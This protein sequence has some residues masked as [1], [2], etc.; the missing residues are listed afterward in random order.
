M[1]EFKPV[2]CVWEFTLACDLRCGHCGSRAGTARPDEMDTAECLG[3]VGSLARLGGRLIT[4]SGG[5]PTLRPDWE[6]VAKAIR[7]RGMIANIVTNG[8]SMTAELARRMKDAGLANAAVSIDGPEAVHEKIRGRGTFAKTVRALSFLADAGVST[9]IMT[10]ANKLNLAHLEETCGMAEK[11]GAAS[12]RVQLGKSMGNLKDRDDWVL[13]PEDLLDL[14]PRLYRLESKGGIRVHIGD[15]IGFYGPYDSRLRA[16][17]WDGKP[18]RWG[19]CQAGLQAIGI[20]S[21]GNIKG[22][23]SMQAFSDRDR[24]PFVE[25]NVRE[26]ALS[27]IWN[28]PAAFSYNRLFRAADLTGFCKT[29]RYAKLCR[30]GAKCVAAAMGPS[31]FEDPYCYYRVSELV[32]QRPLR[33]VAR[34]MAAAASAFSLV[35]GG[36]DVAVTSGDAGAVVE[37]SG[38]P[39]E[40]GGV[41]GDAAVGQDAGPAPDGGGTNCKDVCCECEYGVIPPDVYEECCAIQPEYGVEP[42]DGGVIGEDAGPAPDAGINCGDVCCECDYGVIPPDVY[43]QCCA[44]PEYG[45]PPPDCDKVDPAVIDECCPKEPVDCTVA[46]QCCITLDYGVEPPD[47]GSVTPEQFAECCVSCEDVCCECDYG[48]L[49]PEVNEK[50]CAPKPDCGTVDPAIIDNCCTPPECKDVCCACEYGVQPPDLIEKC[51]K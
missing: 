37:D 38:G 1:P 15:S 32:R 6:V 42:P 29:C 50:C 44:A 47:C 34:H 20:E 28:D 14:L 9:A 12:W 40:D 18:Q 22:C 43:E 30:G 41:S 24:D 36:C 46:S 48:V 45:I 17:S 19:G 51:C 21:N 2:N 35:V 10:T 8:N 16:M 7:D 23:L 27:D 13:E 39:A 49:P 3:V 5:E 31:V 4:L 11:L 33:R 26:R 25:G